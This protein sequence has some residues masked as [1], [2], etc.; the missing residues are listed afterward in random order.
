MKWNYLRWAPWIDTRALFVSS[1]PPGGALLDLGSS[2]GSTLRHFAELR[3]DIRFSASDLAGSP[4]NYPGGTEF[5]RAN[6]ETDRLPWDDSSFDAVTCMH[7]VEHLQDSAHILAEAA[8]VLRPSGRLYVETP[9]PKSVNIPSASGAS[10]GH[11]TLNFFDDDTH[12]APV[13]TEV[14]ADQARNAGLTP[15]ATGTSRN[16]IFAGAY[17]IFAALRSNSRKRFVAQL[18]WMGWSSYVVASRNSY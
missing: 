9:H 1:V 16:L 11:V 14:I 7:V 4:E 15:V 3:P 18:H 12:V 6:F 13:P 8:R 17:P 2:D 5:K 10:A